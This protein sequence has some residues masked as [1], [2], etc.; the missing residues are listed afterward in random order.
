VSFINN[1]ELKMR[2]FEIIRPSLRA[3]IL[4]FHSL[5]VVNA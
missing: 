4:R 5:L 2:T 1:D 3:V